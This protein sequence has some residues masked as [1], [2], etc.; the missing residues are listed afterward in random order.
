MS[1]IWSVWARR[2]RFGALC[3]VDPRCSHKVAVELYLGKICPLCTIVHVF[4][5]L[6]FVVLSRQQSRRADAPLELRELLARALADVSVVATVALFAVVVG[7]CWA[8]ARHADLVG[9]GGGATVR[10][11][12]VECLLRNGVR[13]FGASTCPVCALQLSYV[14]FATPAQKERFYFDCAASVNS[15]ACKQLALRALPTFVRFDAVGA[16]LAR[17]EGLVSAE[18]LAAFADCPQRPLAAD[19]A[20]TEIDRQ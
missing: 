16:P 12:D 10:G 1:S 18:R 9:G 13:M 5:L 6:A 4:T 3:V 15:A 17:L 14:A 7:Y 20:N 19:A 2:A 11:D 8:L